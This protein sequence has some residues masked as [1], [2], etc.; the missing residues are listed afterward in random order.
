MNLINK[1]REVEE[2]VEQEVEDHDL[3]RVSFE[4]VVDHVFNRVFALDVTILVHNLLAYCGNLAPGHA[5]IL[6]VIDLLLGTHKNPFLLPF[7]N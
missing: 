4:N 1:R 7:E 2:H 5:E 3:L 6:T